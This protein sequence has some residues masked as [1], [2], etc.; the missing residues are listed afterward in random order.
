MAYKHANNKHLVSECKG[1]SRGLDLVR[2][3][4][5]KRACK[6]TLKVESDLEKKEERE[7][8][9]VRSEN[10]LSKNPGDWVFPR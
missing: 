5:W 7:G 10:D 1:N 4:S 3:V 9:H 2:E 8:R 6:G